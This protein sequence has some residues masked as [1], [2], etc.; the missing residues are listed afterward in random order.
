MNAPYRSGAAA[1]DQGEQRRHPSHQ[2]EGV[3]ET[4]SLEE[5]L[6]QRQRG[7][8]PEPPDSV[9][10]IRG[11][12]EEPVARLDPAVLHLGARRLHPQEDDQVGTGLDRGKACLHMGHESR[13]VRHVVVR[14]EE[15]DRGQGRHL[16]DAK[17]S[18]TGSPGPCPGRT[19]ERPAA[20]VAPRRGAAHRMARGG[21]SGPGRSDPVARCGRRERASGRATSARPRRGRTAWVARRRRSV[22]SAAGAASPRPRRGSSPTCLVAFPPAPPRRCRH[23]RARLTRL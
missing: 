8:L 7:L 14:W 18:R 19:A 1:S 2:H 9:D 6:R 12:V 17:Q 4:S 5:R 22:V 15:G 20:R 16:G 3:P 11:P 23:G 10:G 21:G 13:I